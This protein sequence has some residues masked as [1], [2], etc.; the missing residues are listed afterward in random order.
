MR[1][2]ALL[3]LIFTLLISTALL[4]QPNKNAFAQ[5]P[6]SGQ[7]C[8]QTINS[9][10]ADA[11][12]SSAEEAT[13]CVESGVYEETITI[14]TNGISLL[15][16]EGAEPVLSGDERRLSTGITIQESD[17]I[18]VEGFT[19]REY[20]DEGILVTNGNSVT[21]S[22]NNI[23]ENHSSGI[24]FTGTVGIELTDNT[25]SDNGSSVAIDY[26]GIHLEEADSVQ[27]I[28]NNISGSAVDGLFLTEVTEGVVDNNTLNNN[29]ENGLGIES[30]EDI[31]VKNNQM[32][33]NS[34]KGANIENVAGLLVEDNVAMNNGPSQITSSG[35]MRIADS[36][37]AIVRGNEANMNGWGGIAVRSSHGV[38]VENN[39]AKENSRPGFEV[40]GSD[41]MTVRQNLSEDNGPYGFNLSGD[42]IEFTNNMSYSNSWD[43]I[44]ITNSS[45][46]E[47]NEALI[48]GNEIIFA[49]DDA[50]S[51][52]NMNNVVIE[53]NTITGTSNGIYLN[54]S[55]DVLITNNDI[56]DVG[57]AG[58][59]LDNSFSTSVESNTITENDIG[60]LATDSTENANLTDNDITGN[61]Q[62]VVADENGHNVDAT[63]NWW[64]ENSGPSGGAID[65]ATGMPATGSGDS[66]TENV[67]FDPWTGK[68]NLPQESVFEVAIDST[69]SP[70]VVGENVLVYAT[71]SNTGILEG[72][73]NITLEDTDRATTDSEE[74]TIGPRLEEQITLG[75]Q[76]ETGDEGQGTL[77]LRSEDDT[78]T[79]P[80]TI[81]TDAGMVEIDQ[82]TEITDPG[83]YEITADLEHGNTC[84]TISSNGVHIEGGGFTINGLDSDAS[85]PRGIEVN[86][87][88]EELLN[89]VT[90]TN[91]TAKNWHLGVDLTGVENST[92]TQVTLQDNVSGLLV[93]DSNNN[94]FSQITT[95][96][97]SRG[98]DI[99]S[100]VGGQTANNTFSEIVANNNSSAGAY[101]TSGPHNQFDM[102]ELNGNENGLYVIASNGNSFSNI[103]A[104]NNTRNGLNLRSSSADNHYSNITA[105]N[106]AW[107]GVE[108]NESDDNTFENVEA[109]GNNMIGILLI[110]DLQ[111]DDPLTGN[112]FTNIV[113]SANQE[114]GILLSV[115]HQNTFESIEVENNNEHGIQLSS[116]SEGNHF[117]NA[118][119]NGN[120]SDEFHFGVM[121]AQNENSGNHFTGLEM[122]GGTGGITVMGNEN[123]FENSSISN[124]SGPAVQFRLD[125][126]GNSLQNSELLNNTTGIE[127]LDDA[128]GNEISNVRVGNSLISVDA[129]GIIIN[130]A[131]EPETLPQNSEST[132]FFV[133]IE[134][135]TENPYV[136]KLSFHYEDTDID[137][138]DEEELSVWRYDNEEW[139][140]AEDESYNSGVDM[141]EKI[142]YA[143][144]ITEFSIFAVL[145]GEMATSITQ[146]E[147]PEEFELRQNYPNPFNPATQITYALPE[148]AD[149]QL[150][151]YNTIGQR[152]AVLVDETQQSGQHEVTFDAGNLASGVYFYRIEAGEFNQTLQMTLIK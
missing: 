4:F 73:Q 30:S 34:E 113:A 83:S 54:E 55:D 39:T 144:N 57:E 46:S 32:S 31:T 147:T 137:G 65:P 6:L 28:N 3:T 82:C 118:T 27:V 70:V 92:V 135:A 101:V 128:Y 53:N 122:N 56:T 123:N 16:A 150:S 61:V 47:I 112:Q 44:R 120:G 107:H 24:K 149:V 45:D 68:D 110:G 29:G 129:I 115:A 23:E 80:V 106:N 20:D 136:D 69:N 131:E 90:I 104:E 140:S 148:A 127:L 84:I 52:W 79:A 88:N 138:L 2:S 134:A 94:E 62:G 67:L 25:L 59:H 95:T 12:E 97:N 58:I 87:G 51:V 143:E 75:W 146:E 66:V 42:Y 35:G 19:I 63:G 96:G 132:G 37:Y 130:E 111:F 105:K 9:N 10:I 1:H 17:N 60:V 117:E 151:V 36:D 43:A 18:L 41:S 74:L 15:A 108:L 152:V 100:S 48:S 125:A 85:F 7:Q 22:S 50:I 99:S 38:L 81:T 91:L 141:V 78:D 76:T 77:T 126:G 13:I 124:M 139:S 93:R 145:S 86:S 14:S 133:G 109:S 98:I 103:S 11:V 116:R 21:I 71:I 26:F 102:L 5:S 8:D 114:S 142:V 64:G 121:I 119:L 40:T 72:T 89:D 49:T 33:E